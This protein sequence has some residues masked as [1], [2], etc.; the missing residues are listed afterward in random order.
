MSVLKVMAAALGLL[1]TGTGAGAAEPYPARAI[2]MVVAYP[3]GGSMDAS[4]RLLANALSAELGHKVVIHHVGG[5]NGMIGAR[6]V[7]QAAPDGYTLLFATNSE[8]VIAPATDP[9]A[10]YQTADLT[11]V[12]PVS[13]TAMVLV[14]HAGLPVTTVGDVAALAAARDAPLAVGITGVGT[15]Q[16]IL[17]QRFAAAADLR[18]LPVPYPGATAMMQDVIGGRLDFGV[19]TLPTALVYLKRRQ[20]R[21]VA[22]FSAARSPLA[23]AIPAINEGNSDLRYPVLEAWTGIFA[24]RGVPARVTT[25]LRS[26]MTNVL[27]DPAL[28]AQQRAMGT[29][30]PTPQA[31]SRFN[32]FVASQA[33]AWRPAQPSTPQEQ[34]PIR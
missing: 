12:A 6:R 15:L 21:P 24:P 7:V 22:V 25:R 23:P 14:A 5:A 4:A 3:A 17:A 11:P 30:T 31:I 29:H 8:A 27:S 9:N 18:W 33:A 26:A 34:G 20:V 32:G 13:S 16:D 1:L 28:A 10:G 19:V 2:T